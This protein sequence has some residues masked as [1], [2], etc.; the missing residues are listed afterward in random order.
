MLRLAPPLSSANEVL[1][2]C[3]SGIGTA[4][5]KACIETGT[6]DLVAIALAYDSS[7][8]AGELYLIPPFPE[9]A[10]ENTIIAAG[11]TKKEF[12]NLYEYYLRNKKKPGRTIYDKLLV[13]ANEKCPFCGGIGRPR[14]LDHYLPKAFFPQFSIVPTNLVPACR[15]CNMDGKGVTYASRIT[16]QIIHPYLDCD[17]FFVEQWV[18]ANVIVG[19]PCSIEYIV[20]P[21]DNWSD[22]DK[23]RVRTHF[24][25]FDLGERFSIQAAEELSIIIDQRRGIMVGWS[26]EDFSEFLTSVVVAPLFINHW[27]RIMY[28]SLAESDDFCNYTF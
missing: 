3:I 28:Q 4:A 19:E 25:D 12:I 14:N 2:T 5:F 27:K 15:D 21:P 22:F 18:S 24:N 23:E 1:N 10:N 8:L 13:A 6:A 20:S 17:H 9:N 16:E 11:I 26:P 7:A